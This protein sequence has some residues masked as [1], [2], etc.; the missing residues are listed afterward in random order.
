MS[1]LADHQHQ[2][3]V[4][5]QLRTS[6]DPIARQHAEELQPLYHDRE[7]AGLADDVYDSARGEGQPGAG[8]IRASE[9]LDK[10]REYA[11]QLNM[12]DDQ[13]RD[14]LKPDSS[15]FRAEIYLPDPAILGP[16]YKPTVA[17]K[18]SAGEV[19][20][21][22]RLRPTGSEDFVANNFP[23]S[24]G[25]R[26]YCYDRAMNHATSQG[27]QVGRSLGG[28]GSARRAARFAQAACQV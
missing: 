5:E 10:L 6:S 12:T 17:Y 13:I 14:L 19:L 15:G 4:L 11:P 26:T 1:T 8:W 23:Q 3:T 24:V 2:R 16:G 22:D 25:L 7:M 21:P 18:G 27:V 28:R 20:T 9:H